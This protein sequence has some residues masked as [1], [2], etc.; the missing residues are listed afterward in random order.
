MS[1][2]DGDIRTVCVFGATGRQ[3]RAQI[4]AALAA[5]YWVRALTRDVAAFPQPAPEGLAVMHADYK[6]AASLARACRG[7]DA[8]FVTP[9]SFTE[10][11]QNTPHIIELARIAVDAG[12][13]RFVLNTSMFVPNEPI[14][15]PIYD[16]RLALEN[17]IEATGAPLTVFRPVLFMDNLL[18]DW[19]LPRLL[20]ED[21]FVYPHHPGM[22]A[23]WVCLDDVAECMVKSL[24]DPA[25]VGERIVIGGPETLQPS[26]VAAILS[27]VLERPI[28]YRQ[29]T[30]REFA[31]LLNSIFRN[32]LGIPNEAHIAAI[33]AFYTYNNQSNLR[34][35]VV[36]VAKM[37][38]KI[39]VPMQT[40]HEWA[41]KQSWSH[42][43]QGEAAP[44]GG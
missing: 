22:Q 3:G 23:N 38:E 28:E 39:D 34:P 27:D 8:V 17:A 19:V 20:N 32:V 2:I 43:E 12:V 13:K 41:A 21:L 42:R 35:M 16:G 36:D 26:D 5:G 9:P 30:P 40:L 29:S 33:D 37:R 7:A 14:G 10:T 44:I 18:R 24:Q 4:K 6:D 31:E 1:A 11:V 15:E 25:L